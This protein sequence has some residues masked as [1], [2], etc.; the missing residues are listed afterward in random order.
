MNDTQ[1]A[2]IHSTKRLGVMVQ[3]GLLAGP[4]MSMIDSSVVNVALRYA[5]VIQH[6]AQACLRQH[7]AVSRQRLQRLGLKPHHRLFPGRPMNPHVGYRIPP[8]RRLPVEVIQVY[9]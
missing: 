4:F 9:E 7:V 1:N 3:M 6:L 2:D 5:T 8:R